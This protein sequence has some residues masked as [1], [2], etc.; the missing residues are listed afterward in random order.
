M[1]SLSDL[2]TILF[3]FIN[4]DTANPLFDALMPFFSGN[5]AFFPM[6]AALIVVLL[7]QGGPRT[8]AYILVM[9]LTVLVASNWVC[10]PLKE[11]FMRARPAM[12]LEDVRLLFGNGKGLTSMP[13][14]HA[15]NWGAMAMVTWLFHRSTWKFMVPLALL[16]A[17]SRVYLGVH[18]PTDVMAGLAIGAGAGAVIVTGSCLLW[19]QLG[20]RILPAWWAKCPSLCGYQPVIV[21]DHLVRDRDVTWRNATWILL[22]ALLMVRL[23]Y[24]ASDTIQLSEDEAYQ[25]MWSRN[26]D[27]AYYSKPPIIAW[28]QWM[29]THLWGHTEFGVRFFAP[30]LAFT[31]G[32]MMW[33]FV[34]E[35]ASEKAA[36]ILTVVFATTPLFA[37]GSTLLTV[38]APTVFFHTAS[39][40]AAW[41]A[42]ERDSTRWWL[43]AGVCMALGFLS[44]FFS[45]F[46][47]AG[48]LTFLIWSPQYRHQLRRP[49]VWIALVLNLVG[50]LPVLI[51]NSN[52]GWITL[53][54]LQERG[55]LDK[56]ASFNL[57]SLG[58]FVGS[59][60]GLLNP[61]FF[62]AALAAVWGFIKLR[63]KPALWRYLFCMSVPVFGFY[64]ILACRAKAQPN[65]I[66]PAAPTLFLFAAFWWHSQGNLRAA[67][68]LLS[69]GLFVGIPLVVFLHDTHLFHKVTGVYLSEKVD[70]LNR[71]R[72]GTELA[73]I[74]REQRKL[75]EEKGK[76]VF[77]IADHYGRASLL[78]FYLQ[79][80]P[81]FVRDGKIAYTLS[82]TTPHNQYWFWPGYEAREGENAIYVTSGDSK[83]DLPKRL[84]T[85]FRHIRK[86]GLYTI[87]HEGKICGH[88]QL[89]A[90]R[91][92]LPAVASKSDGHAAG[93]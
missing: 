88:V 37:V 5:A 85:E 79:T 53:T 63:N 22:A 28:I 27:W 38:D 14:C 10:A 82:T 50:A 57:G 20:R 16:V 47:W 23:A 74:V 31:F 17:Y 18:Y 54:H 30:V 56:S 26:L 11:F 36:F 59:I 1:A 86:L 8:L 58:E 90:C 73:E 87:R 2:D 52:H 15:T 81:M 25:W 45:P 29:G 46:F 69:L 61:A 60:A 49:G 68:W 83:R 24:I 89:F 51:W 33:M 77:L 67:R 7:Y 92:K 44:K 4:R 72:G 70:P 75:L 32:I 43:G 34:R 41:V 9:T 66:G 6:L 12:T 19:A 93:R 55:G 40:L 91:E 65:W 76:P 21:S 42:I 39:V 48:M 13:S 64:L 78:N 62:A 3:H 80:E 84:R 35:R 71:V